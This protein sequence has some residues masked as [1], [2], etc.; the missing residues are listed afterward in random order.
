MRLT[1]LA[2]AACLALMPTLGAAQS[3]DS[4]IAARTGFMDVLAFTAAPL[5]AMAKGDMPWDADRAKRAGADLTRL[6]GYDI[7]ALF[8]AGSSNEDKKGSTRALPAIWS[9]PAGFARQVED[10]RKG[11]AAL[12]AAVESG[13]SAL[14]E[15]MQTF[16]ATCA[17][18]HR[19]YRAREF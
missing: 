11:I 1:R 5:A 12:A 10:L 18:C 9:D 19:A 3:I 14:G 13:P 7:E 6:A 8:P 15:G 4:A 17:A 2:A 16:G